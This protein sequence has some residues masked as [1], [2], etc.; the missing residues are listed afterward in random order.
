MRFIES[1]NVTFIETLP[2][3]LNMLD[4]CDNDSDD[5]TVL[6]LESTS[7]V[8]GTKKE[9]QQKET[10]DESNAGGSKSGSEESDSNVGSLP[11]EA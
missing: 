8:V 5:V 10:H 3:N 9:Q 1:R 6:D 7:I 2:V 11:K 4:H